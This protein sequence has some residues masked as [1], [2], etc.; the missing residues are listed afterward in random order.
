MGQI[1][2]LQYSPEL[3][4]FIKKARDQK[5]SWQEIADELDVSMTPLTSFRKE[6][7]DLLVGYD[8]PLGKTN[9][10][11][12]T[13][14]RVEL[15]RSMYESDTRPTL[16]DMCQSLGVSI[17]VLY[18]WLDEEY[19]ERLKE[20]NSDKPRRGRPRKGARLNAEEFA[21]EQ[22]NNSRNMPYYLG[23]ASLLELY[24][25]IEEGQELELIRYT[26][27]HSEE[28]FEEMLVQL[29]VLKKRREFTAMV[30]EF[31]PERDLLH[32]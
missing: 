12:K 20:Q 23:N 13:A 18:R 8:N 4:D 15:L 32:Y 17:H 3:I 29:K 31:D 5:R 1:K 2:K 27:G 14:E 26:L 9:K 24:T 6:Y 19:P 16:K 21:E 30:A 10:A 25:M 7:A 22:Y 28:V 11:E